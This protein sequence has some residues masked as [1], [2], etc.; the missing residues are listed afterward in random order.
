MFI[1]I[2]YKRLDNRVPVLIYLTTLF[3]VMLAV[4]ISG[5]TRSSTVES[6]VFLAIAFVTMVLA[7]GLRDR[8]VGT[9][10]ST[11]IGNFQ[12]LQT[13]ADAMTFG[14]YTGEYGYWILNWLLHF[15]SDKYM[16]LLVVIAVVVVGCYQLTIVKYSL[17]HLISFFVFMTM[18][19]YTFFFN[20]ARQ[21]IA[22]AIYALA[23]GPLFDRNLIKYLGLVLL[24]SLFHKTAIMTL[25][26]YFVFNKDNTIKTNLLIF[27]IGVAGAYFFQNF[28]DLGKI[29]DERYQYYGTGTEGGGYYIIGLMSLIGCFFLIYKNF[30]HVYRE[31]YGLFLNMFLFGVMI[32][33]VSG[34]M[35]A[36]PSGVLRFSLYFNISAVFLWPIVFKNLANLSGKILIIFIFVIGHLTLYAL[37]TERFSNLIPY[38]FNPDLTTLLPFGY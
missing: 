4:H 13:F 7:A 25:P 31:Q 27:L 38:T 33:V 11:Y 34:L 22:C 6:K 12:S 14:S 2:D 10:T 37:T 17:N 15:V 36:N 16:V 26:V 1:S 23:I 8:S 28:V 30:I 32:S 5:K 24:A 3:I 20:G 9:D 21:G 29:F 18:G 35:G 19:F